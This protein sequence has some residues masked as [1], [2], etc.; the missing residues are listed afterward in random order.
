MAPTGGGDELSNTI[1]VRRHGNSDSSTH[2]NLTN[3]YFD[4]YCSFALIGMV[5]LL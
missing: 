4:S 2:S 1:D 3:Y 5:R